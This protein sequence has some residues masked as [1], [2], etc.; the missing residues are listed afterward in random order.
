MKTYPSIPHLPSEP[1]KKYRGYTDTAFYAFGKNDG[2]NIRVEWTPKG[3]FSKWGRRTGLLD[4]SNPFLKEAPGLFEARYSDMESR[5]G[6]LILGLNPKEAKVTLF[7]EFFGPGSKFGT[8]V[9]E[10]HEV[11]LFDIDIYKKGLLTPDKFCDI[12][13][14]NHYDGLMFITRGLW[15]ARSGEQLQGVKDSLHEGMPRE[16]VVLKSLDGKVY[17]KYKAQRWYD[18]LRERCGTDAALFESLK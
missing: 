4:D 12:L 14:P 16:G 3:G 2:S 9:D 8:H 15:D 5:L 1:G 18:D 6:E 7:M 13:E 17:F 10:P 11:Q